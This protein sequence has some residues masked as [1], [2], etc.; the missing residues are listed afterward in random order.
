MN[1]YFVKFWWESSGE[2]TVLMEEQYKD[3][4]EGR[5]EQ[6]KKEIIS[7]L[8]ELG[9]PGNYSDVNYRIEKVDVEI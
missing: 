7:K 8:K 3:K 9:S 6:I 2:S 4:A 5:A 1:K